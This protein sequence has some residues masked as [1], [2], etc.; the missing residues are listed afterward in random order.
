MNQSQKRKKNNLFLR[1]V[2]GSILTLILLVIILIL[3]VFAMPLMVLMALFC[4][5]WLAFSISLELI[6]DILNWRKK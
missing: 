1:I 3:M 4:L 5:I 6:D 2:L